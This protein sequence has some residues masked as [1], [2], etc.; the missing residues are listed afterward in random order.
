LCHRLITCNIAKRSQAPEKGLMVIDRDLPMINMDEL[1]RLQICD[2]LG[3]TWAWVALRPERLEEEVHGMRESLDEQ[4]EVIDAMARDF[5][6]LEE[7]VHGMRESLDEQREVMDA[8]ARDFSRFTVWAASGI[9]HLLDLS[10]ATYTRYS[11]MHVPYQ[12]RRT[13]PY[14]NTFYTFQYGISWFGIW[15][16]DFL[17]KTGSAGTGEQRVGSRKSKSTSIEMSLDRLHYMVIDG[18]AIWIFSETGSAGTGEQRR[19]ISLEGDFL[20][21]VASYT[22]IRDPLMRLCHRLITCNI[23]KRS[24][25]P[26]KVTSTD[27]FY[28]RS[29]DVGAVNIPFLLA[30]YLRR[31]ASRGSRLQGLTVINRDLPVID[32]DEL[33]RLQIGRYLG[34]GSPE[35]R[36]APQPPLAT[37]LVVRTI[38]QRMERLEEEV[39]GMRK[40]LDEQR[41]VMDAMARDFS[42]FTVWA[43]S[44]ISHLLDLSRATY[45]RTI[46]Q[47]MERLEEE[48]DPYFNTFY[49]FQ[50]GVSW[51]GIRRIDFLYRPRWK[52]IDNIGGVSI[53]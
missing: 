34:L 22:S 53:I 31:Y 47:R 27:L 51:F 42:R 19:G 40:S 44:G 43:A 4:Q 17:Y 15:R 7:E 14:S 11:K 3:D 20:G 5:S 25:A 1:V 18:C 49:T 28:L 48:T 12:R 24:Q 16:I 21:V 52:E 38:P 29:M 10:R 23:A 35:T 46:P 9:S 37:A 39:H 32:M 26:E 8:L 45:T 50:Y 2:R 41:E 13:D 6:R 33:V 36:E 30:Q